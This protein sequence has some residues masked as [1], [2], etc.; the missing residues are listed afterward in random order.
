MAYYGKTPSQLFAK[1]H[2]QRENKEYYSLDQWQQ[3][4]YNIKEHLSALFPS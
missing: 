2:P 1:P 4:S 3:Q